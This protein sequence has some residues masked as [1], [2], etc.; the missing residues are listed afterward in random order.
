MM[1]MQQGNNYRNTYFEIP[2]LTKIYG[3]PMTGLLFILKN[4]VKANAM[5][6]PTTLRGGACR[7]LGLVLGVTQYENIPG[8]DLY[9]KTT[10]PAGPLN[11]RQGL[12]LYQITQARDYHQ[13][14]SLESSILQQINCSINNIFMY[15]FDTYGDITPQALQTLQDNVKT[16]HFD[17]IKP[18]DAILSKIDNLTSIAELAQD[19]ISEKQKISI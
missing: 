15:L 5:T 10:Y 18:V 14:D 16:M 7:H 6:V 3:K 17:P 8:T 1:S 2:D 13:D 9:T 12:T 19:P 4:E 11:M